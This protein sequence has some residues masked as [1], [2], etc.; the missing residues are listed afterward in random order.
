M[1]GNQ[2]RLLLSVAFADT[3][4]EQ[5][6]LD[7]SLEEFFRYGYHDAHFLATGIA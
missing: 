1:A 5:I 6:A 2:R 7:S 4:L 3:S